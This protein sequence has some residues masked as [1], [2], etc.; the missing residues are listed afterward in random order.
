LRGGRESKSE[1]KVDLHSSGR[2]FSAFTVRI[3]IESLMVGLL[4]RRR[5]QN[6]TPGLESDARRPTAGRIGEKT[7]V[8]EM[9][10]AGRLHAERGPS[11]VFR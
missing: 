5:Q 7:S 11:G 6:E 1:R 10:R 2:G 3:A 4:A 8:S 9:L